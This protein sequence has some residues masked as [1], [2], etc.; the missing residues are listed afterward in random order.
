MKDEII[1]GIRNALERGATLEEAVKSFV[2]AGY[3]PAEV[4]EAASM[5]ATS[6]SIIAQPSH[7]S[8]ISPPFSNP[9]ILP[10]PEVQKSQTPAILQNNDNIR[11]NASPQPKK[12]NKVFISL[13]IL[14]LGLIALLILLVI[15]KDS[16]LQAMFGK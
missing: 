8:N 2:N 1:G 15:F 10:N 16:I 9:P 3:N 11:T 12:T 14:F 7:A 6:A 4:R 13:L 5:L